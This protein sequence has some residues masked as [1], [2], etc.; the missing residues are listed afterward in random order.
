MQPHTR[1]GDRAGEGSIPPREHATARRRQHSRAQA[2]RRAMALRARVLRGRVATDWARRVVFVC[3]AD[4][5][6]ESAT[7]N[8]TRSPS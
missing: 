6:C 2:T 7:H 8:L 5:L 1:G 3:T 4:S